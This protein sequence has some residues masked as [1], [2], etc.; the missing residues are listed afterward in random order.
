MRPDVRDGA[1]SAALQ[2]GAGGR[3]AWWEAEGGVCFGLDIPVGPWTAEDVAFW[4]GTP[5]YQPWKDV[6]A[7]F[8]GNH[9][10][11]HAV[12]QPNLST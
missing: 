10:A 8:R 4:T 11:G 9:P 12:G 7:F 6:A 2:T 5:R 3:S 1:V